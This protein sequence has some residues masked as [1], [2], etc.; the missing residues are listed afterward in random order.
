MNYIEIRTQ[1]VMSPQRLYRNSH[2][3]IDATAR[4]ILKFSHD[5]LTIAELTD[6]G[7][8]ELAPEQL[9]YAALDAAVT[10]K[11]LEKVLESVDARISIDHLLKEHN[12][13]NIIGIEV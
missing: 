4:T 2:L 10:P 1:F 7:K 5:C 8:R 3:I 13:L 12:N 9:E 6:W 11:L